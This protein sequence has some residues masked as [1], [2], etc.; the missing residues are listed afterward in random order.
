MASTNIIILNPADK[1]RH[2][3][4]AV[5]DGAPADGDA[6]VTDTRK[7]PT[8]SQYTDLTGKDFYVRMASAKVA[9]DWVKI[10][11]EV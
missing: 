5:G 4:I 3:T 9:A 2:C 1:A 7:Y 11:A 8:G 6:I 10:N